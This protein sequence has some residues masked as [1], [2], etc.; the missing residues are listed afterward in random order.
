MNERRC[1]RQALPRLPVLGWSAFSG[2][3]GPPVAGILSARHYRHTISGRAAIVLALQVL[4]IKAGDKVLVPTYHCP[5]MIAPV[6]QAGAQPVFYPITASGSPSLRWLEQ[7]VLT[8]VKAMLATH[9]FGLPQPMSQ[10][11][12]FCVARGINL[13]EDCAH[14][15]FGISDNLPVGSWGDVSIASLTKFFPVSEGGVIASHTRPLN[16]LNLPSRGW[17]GEIKAAADAIEVGVQYGRF[18]GLSSILACLFSVKNWMPHGDRRVDPPRISTV[19]TRGEPE[20]EPLLSSSRPALAASWIARGV[21]KHRIVALRRRNYV[22]LV[23]RLSGLAG[24]RALVADLPESAAPY[25]FPLYVDDPAASYQRLRSAGIPIF[26]WDEIWPG[27]PAIEGDYGQDWSTHV[28][29]LGCHQ[30]VSPEDIEAMADI[31]RTIIHDG[32]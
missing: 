28:F 31:V 4:G 14:A 23:S 8:G 10:F 27:T 18:P 2:E 25:V 16:T 3:Q 1:I 7:A 11:R 19:D 26:R 15:F 20:V 9:Y 5:T 30:D 24:A 12:E 22:R 29:Q 17:Y 6:A 21:N 13:I 32:A